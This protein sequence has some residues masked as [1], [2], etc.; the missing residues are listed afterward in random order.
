M[1]LVEIWF[2][3]FVCAF[4]LLEVLGDEIPIIKSNAPLVYWVGGS[5]NNDF[6][7]KRSKLQNFNQTYKSAYMGNSEMLPTRYSTRDTSDKSIE[8][9]NQYNT[10]LEDIES[11]P[12]LDNS[13]ATS[14][15][16]NSE[17][18]PLLNK[19]K[20]STLLDKSEVSPL[21]DES[22]VSP[23]INK[24]QVSTLLETSQNI[25]EVTTSIPKHDTSISNIYSRSESQLVDNT[26]TPF[27]NEISLSESEPNYKIPLAS[28]STD[29]YSVEPELESAFAQLERMKEVQETAKKGITEGNLISKPQLESPN[30][31][32][33]KTFP[34]STSSYEADNSDEILDYDRSSRETSSDIFNPM[35]LSLPEINS[36]ELLASSEESENSNTEG[37]DKVV[38]VIRVEEPE[39]EESQASILEDQISNE[40]YNG[41]SM[42]SEYHKQII[43]DSSID[44]QNI[45]ENSGNIISVEDTEYEIKK[46]ESDNIETEDISGYGI[47]EEESENILDNNENTERQEEKSDNIRTEDISGYEIQKEESGNILDNNENTERQEEKSDNIRTEDISGYEI[48]KE[49][50]GNILDNNENTERQE[51]KS[52]NIRTEDISGYEIQ[53]EESGNILDNNE[54]TERQ[55]EKSDNIRTEDISGY[56]IQKEESGNILDNNE[57]TE[58]QEEKSD[59][60]RTEDISGY[61]IQK[62]E[63]EN[64]LDN[65]EN[66]E[67]QE[68]KSDNIRTEDISEYEV[69]KEESENIL[70]SKNN[71]IIEKKRQSEG[72]INGINL[73]I[74]NEQSQKT[75]QYKTIDYTEKLED[76]MQKIYGISK[77]NLNNPTMYTM[78]SEISE[79][80]DEY[81]NSLNEQDTDMPEKFIEDTNKNLISK[82]TPFVAQLQRRS[83]ILR[84]ALL[85]SVVQLQNLLGCAPPCPYQRF[86]LQLDRTLKTISRDE[87]KLVKIVN[88]INIARYI[89]MKE[90]TN[91]LKSFNKH[92]KQRA[93]M[94]VQR[95]SKAIK[96]IQ[97]NIKQYKKV[98]FITYIARLLLQ[99]LPNKP[100][101][102]YSSEEL[103]KLHEVIVVLEKEFSNL[104]L[105]VDN[106]PDLKIT[107]IKLLSDSE[108]R[109]Y[110][111]SIKMYLKEEIEDISAR[112]L[113][114]QKFISKHGTLLKVLRKK[115]A[116]AGYPINKKFIIFDRKGLTKEQH[117]AYVKSAQMDLKIKKQY[118]GKQYKEFNRKEAQKWKDLKSVIKNVKNNINLKS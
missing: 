27:T 114:F 80:S 48:Q 10:L 46:E 42:D 66:T 61:E 102:R 104:R 76:P 24:P 107:L 72:I 96:K 11:S 22:E 36:T 77:S 2:F 52:D 12:L 70:E 82:I 67:R 41:E 69:Q 115:M 78:E 64:I 45:T 18:L 32:N 38:E 55:E 1:G 116:D 35:T 81:Y 6:S 34:I 92:A 83:D 16:D 94:F 47:Q 86:C 14:L 74:E 112:M 71:G 23:L 65:N 13:E 53:K 113:K 109:N 33:T 95:Y 44:T 58:R 100:L 105:L 5:K 63:S 29:I 54:N 49:E 103:V 19:S 28:R 51:E 110:I 39:K 60:I 30:Y 59:N 56:D 97:N 3:T 7:S 25:S 106:Q 111:K 91:S 57:N 93:F 40:P 21:L 50:S 17:V 20:I 89:T 84:G 99:R 73:G 85:P 87:A 37:N 75:S 62:E 90:T 88:I 4:Y 79:M 98:V 117:R 15:S 118:L 68:E 8:S 31:T 101:Q 26:V 108:N 9:K 43:Q